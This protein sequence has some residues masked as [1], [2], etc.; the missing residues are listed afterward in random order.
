ML[1]AL[2]RKLLPNRLRFVVETGRSHIDQKCNQVQ[3]KAAAYCAVGTR[4]G[5]G[6]VVRGGDTQSKK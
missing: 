1:W 6:G 3:K 5:G 2:N 4:G